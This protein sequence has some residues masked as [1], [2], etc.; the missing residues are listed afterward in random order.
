MI[1]PRNLARTVG[2]LS[3]NNCATVRLESMSYSSS[4]HAL[5][6]KSRAMGVLSGQI[7]Y[8]LDRDFEVF[9]GSGSDIP[10]TCC[11]LSE[12]NDVSTT[13]YPKSCCQG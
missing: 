10:S 11:N 8:G 5:G 6:N 2:Q 9:G 1:V 12:G 4:T 13:V 7:F 3:E